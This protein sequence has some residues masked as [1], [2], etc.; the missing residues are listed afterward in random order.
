MDEEIEKKIAI[1]SP[2]HWE[3]KMRGQALNACWASFRG[4]SAH[5]TTLDED[6][7]YGLE[8]SILTHELA[9]RYNYT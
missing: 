4:L 8:Q 6:S 1:V 2:A 3:G 5:L 7:L 9:F